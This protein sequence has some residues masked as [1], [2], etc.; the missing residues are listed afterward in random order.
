[1]VSPLHLLGALERFQQ[2]YTMEK[3]VRCRCCLLALCFLLSFMIYAEETSSYTYDGSEPSGK[4]EF[5]QKLMKDVTKEEPYE[6]TCSKQVH[7]G[8]ETVCHDVRKER[9]HTVSG[10]CGN[11]TKRVCH[12]N[13]PQKVCTNTP[14][15]CHNYTD[16]VCK[17]RPKTCKQVCNGGS[18]RQVCVGGDTFCTNVTKKKCTGGGQTCRTV[19]GGQSCH[20]ESVYSCDPDRRV[21]EPYYD[22]VCNEEARFRTEYYSCTKYRSYTVQEL[23]Y[24]LDAIANLNFTE[25]A[26]SS[27]SPVETFSLSISKAGKPTLS[28]QD[29]GKYLISSNL[30]HFNMQEIEPQKKQAI[31]NYDIQLIPLSKFDSLRDAQIKEVLF[32]S[33]ERKIEVYLAHHISFLPHLE[34]KVIKKRP[35]LDKIKTL[36]EGNIKASHIEIKQSSEG[37]II[38][39]DLSQEQIKWSKGEYSFDIELEISPEIANLLNPDLLPKIK[40]KETKKVRVSKSDL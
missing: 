35:V 4:I 11:R 6:A 39:I 16:R 23:D 18:C 21:C 31:A 28:V 12:N 3:K 20:N 34:I 9:C 19:G 2:E 7:D 22:K 5:S 25:E 24:L 32:D 37:S 26:N 38:E 8:Y 13:P 17:Q 10:Q 15:S 33:K 40:I 1:M 29:S 36:F 27:D 30:T 14:Q